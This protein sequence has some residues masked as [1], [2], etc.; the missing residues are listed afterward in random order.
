M[1]ELYTQGISSAEPLQ[2]ISI[3]RHEMDKPY[4]DSLEIGAA[5][6]IITK[7]ATYG[8]SLLLAYGS[9]NL[10][11]RTYLIVKNRGR[12]Q[13]RVGD[14]S[15]AAIYEEGIPIEPGETKVFKVGSTVSLYARAMGYS[16][17]LE[18]AEV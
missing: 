6:D 10:A 12:N 18:I 1:E 8:A 4:P 16:A 17:D 9:A 5:P 3:M 2:M 13:V 15:T 14:Q 7:T 11:D